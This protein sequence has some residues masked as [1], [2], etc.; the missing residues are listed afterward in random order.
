[1][2]VTQLPLVLPE[3]AITLAFQASLDCTLEIWNTFACRDAHYIR[4]CKAHLVRSSDAL[5]TSG[6]SSLSQADVGAALQVSFNLGSLRQVVNTCVQA[7]AERIE[8]SIND[9]LDAKKL[10]AVAAAG[11]GG[12]GRGQTGATARAQSALWDALDDC[13]DTLRQSATEVWQLQRVVSKKRDPLTLAAF[14]DVVQVRQPGT[15][16]SASA[17]VT[18][19]H[20][21]CIIL[22]YCHTLCQ[23]CTSGQ[24][25]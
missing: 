5:L 3:P 19:L 17:C 25:C 4:D 9:A 15:C 11:G 16:H 21:R 24:A 23:L 6:L 1:M 22:T 7:C 10:S 18:H 8:A 13:M 2:R 14:A 20:A 12:G